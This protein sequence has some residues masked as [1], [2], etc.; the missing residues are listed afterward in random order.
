M[1]CQEL[2]ESHR[3]TK[4]NECACH[5]LPLHI[6]LHNPFIRTS[7]S[8]TSK[9]IPQGNVMSSSL[10]KIAAA[11][12]CAQ[13]AMASP[14]DRPKTTLVKSTRSTS[15]KAP[16]PTCINA[17]QRDATFDDLTGVPGV[18]FNPIPDPYM[19]L[20]YQGFD[21]TTIVETDVAPGIIPHSGTK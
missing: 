21:F 14:W 5:I 3:G 9:P 19:G 17:V 6:N 1:V 20:Y 13:A 12:L 15:S 16:A 8:A 10:F 11:A 2:E 18:E 7:S 4:D